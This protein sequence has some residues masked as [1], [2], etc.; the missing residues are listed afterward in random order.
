MYWM[1]DKTRRYYHAV[2]GRDLLGDLVVTRTTGSVDSARGRVMVFPVGSYSEAGEML[3]RVSVDR[4]RHG[5]RLI[6][7]RI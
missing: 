4:E 2:V 3:D 7:E 1:N 5:Y 6:S